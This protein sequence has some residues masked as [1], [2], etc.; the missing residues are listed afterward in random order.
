MI[1]RD[2]NGD[3]VNVGDLVWF[4]QE[5]WEV[6]DI[7]GQELSLTDLGFMVSN[8]NFVQCPASFVEVDLGDD[9]EPGGQWLD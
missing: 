8:L 3:V 6:V 7:E 2:K 1:S 4:N 5:L 9:D